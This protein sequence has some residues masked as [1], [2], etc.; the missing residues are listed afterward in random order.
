MP[1]P[2]LAGPE[3][4]ILAEIVANKRLELAQRRGP[5]EHLHRPA[6][7]GPVRDFRAALSQPGH[8][9]IMEC[10][11]ASPSQGVIRRQFTLAEIA[12]AYDGIA[13]V[14]SVLTD[15]T[16]F[17]GH[18]DHLADVRALTAAPL[19][20]KDFTLEPYQ[21]REAWAY[22][23]DAVLLMLSVLDDATYRDCAAEAKRLGLGI[24]TE[25][26]DAAELQRAITLGAEIIGINNRDLKT[27]NID[28][29]VT[30]LLAPQVPSDRLVVSESGI[31]S[32]ADVQRLSGHAKAFLVGSSLMKAERVDLAARQL[33]YGA[34]KICGLTRP[35]D[36]ET[37]YRHGA[38]FGGLIFAPESPRRIS[39]PQ[40]KLVQQA[41]PLQYV[42]VF[43]RNDI[44]EIV[45]IARELQLFAVQ[46]HG[47]HSET[48]IVTVKALLPGVEVW[49]VERVSGATA[50]STPDSSATAADRLLF[51]SGHGQA[52]GGNGTVFDW[53]VLPP[54]LPRARLVL[55]GGLT[56]DNIHAARA[57][58]AG[59]LDVN[60]GV[61][62]APGI[63]DE[64]KLTALF[65]ALRE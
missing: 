22:G 56:P 1:A 13:D 3:R 29:A 60:S 47:E 7:F 27:L 25:V 28:L 54:S 14:V 52:R 12:K 21:V 37:A 42:G 30:E 38:S 16:Y 9:F 46:L 26:H 62:T 18:L 23:A 51:D 15:E 65:A 49:K 24:L 17:G 41:A 2:V 59:V 55:A 43:T 45:A 40:A 44:D 8:R 32:H 5:I 58:G 10:K 53:Q 34:V 57:T 39:L 11:R 33:A 35:A 31:G 20:R 48:D 61:E 6:A 19:L 50:V 63:K 64:Q 36:A 4:N